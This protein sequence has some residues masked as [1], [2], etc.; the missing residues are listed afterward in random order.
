LPVLVRSP[1]PGLNT[2]LKTDRVYLC[3]PQ[4]HPLAQR[5]QVWLRE[6]E[7]EPYIDLSVGAP[8]RTYCAQLFE[9]A[10]IKVNRVL[11]CDASICSALIDAEFGAALTSSAYEVDMLKPNCY[12][13]IADEFSHREMALFWN[14]KKY[15]SKAALSFRD[16]CSGYWAKK[17]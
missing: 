14:P 13:P 15:M 6:L 9:R 16:F 1:T 10:G 17:T 12:V 7:N 4:T 11:E 2:V 3:V 5:Q 8:W